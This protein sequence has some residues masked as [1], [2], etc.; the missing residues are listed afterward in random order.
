VGPAPSSGAKPLLRNYLQPGPRDAEKTVEQFIG[1]LDDPNLYGAI[2]EFTRGGAVEAR[3]CLMFISF[4]SSKFPT[5]LLLNKDPSVRPELFV[6]WGG[7]ILFGKHKS[8][9]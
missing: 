3:V 8:K 7:V 2:V 6:K 4:P 1:I 5:L 9:Y